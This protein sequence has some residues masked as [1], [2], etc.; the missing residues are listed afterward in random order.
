MPQV[1]SGSIQATLKLMGTLSLREETKIQLL[2]FLFGSAAM[3]VGVPFAEY[4]LHHEAR[5]GR[6]SLSRER[7]L[8]REKTPV[9]R[10]LS[11]PGG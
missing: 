1:V 10:G 9:A 4:F 8:L 6:R 11:P 2:P 5:G 7:L 3:R